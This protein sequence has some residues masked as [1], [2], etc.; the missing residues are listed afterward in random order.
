MYFCHLCLF[1]FNMQMLFGATAKDFFN[2]CLMVIVENVICCWWRYLLCFVQSFGDAYRLVDIAGIEA[3][4][5]PFIV[6]N[7]TG[8]HVSIKPDDSFEVVNS[9]VW[10]ADVSYVLTL[11]QVVYKIG[12]ALVENS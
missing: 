12:E 7:E 3:A 9:S 8:M 4:S 1:L 2:A 5:L 6:K 10:S 11:L